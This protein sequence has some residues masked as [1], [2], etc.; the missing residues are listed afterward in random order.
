MAWNNDCYVI[1][2]FDSNKHNKLLSLYVKVHGAPSILGAVSN[3]V[4][5][6]TNDLSRIVSRE[7]E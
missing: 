2:L 7:K 6:L 1:A 4:K 3:K 5:Y